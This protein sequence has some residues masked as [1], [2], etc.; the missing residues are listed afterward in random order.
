MFRQPGFY[1]VGDSPAVVNCGRSC[2]V[3]NVP[4]VMLFSL[5]LMHL[6]NVMN[7]PCKVEPEDV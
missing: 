2:L 7:Q 5:K 4:S 3:P 6:R 1:E